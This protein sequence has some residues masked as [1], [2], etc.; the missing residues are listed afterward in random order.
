VRTTTYWAGV[1]QEGVKWW[2]NGV[3]AASIT[4]SAAAATPTPTRT[5]LPSGTL[6][7]TGVRFSP[8][9]LASGNI[10]QVDIGVR[11]NSN[12]VAVTEGPPPGFTYNEGDTPGSRGYP[13]ISGR[14]RVGV[15]FNGR[16]GLDHPYRWGLGADLAPGASVTVTGYIKLATARTTAYWAG[17]VQEGM[18]WVQNG[19]GSTSITVTPAGSPARLSITGVRFSPQTLLSGQVLQVDVTVR[20]DGGLTAQTQGPDPGFTYNEGDTMI[21]RGY[22]EVANAWRVGVDFAGRTGIDHPYRWGLGA[23][24]AP[25]A[26]ATI[27]GYLKLT[28]PGTKSYWV[29]V[30]QEAVRWQQDKVGTANITVN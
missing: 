13:D 10:V 22:S 27:T 26:S 28:T 15:D 21:S 11:N 23:P 6:A 5:P 19:M 3:G 14:W 30:V 2:Q 18:A 20:N 12:A 8:T 7:I 25:G 1:V 17:L 29:G 4:V 9:T 24:L 16:T